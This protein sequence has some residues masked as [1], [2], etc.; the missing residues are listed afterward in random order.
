MR[1]SSASIRSLLGFSSARK[2]ATSYPTVTMARGSR[3][4]GKTPRTETPSAPP[5]PSQPSPSDISMPI[6]SST[7]PISQDCTNN[8]S[9][10]SAL[11]ASE[12]FEF[13]TLESSALAGPKIMKLGFS[14]SQDAQGLAISSFLDG[15]KP[16]A[17]ATDDRQFSAKSKKR[18]K[19]KAKKA[20]AQGQGPQV[21]AISP[22]IPPLDYCGPMPA[23]PTSRKDPPIASPKPNLGSPSVSPPLAFA[24]PT[25][26]EEKLRQENEKLKK[27]L[28]EANRLAKG[29]KESHLRLEEEVEAWK[30]KCEGFS[31]VVR[32]LRTEVEEMI[33]FRISK[34]FET[35]EEEKEKGGKEQEEKE[36]ERK[37]KEGEETERKERE[38]KEKG[39]KEKERRIKGG[40]EKEGKE[41]KGKVGDRKEGEGKAEDVE[42]KARQVK[43]QKSYFDQMLDYR[44]RKKAE[45]RRRK[46]WWNRFQRKL[47]SNLATQFPM[48]N[49]P[50]VCTT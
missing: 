50:L 18:S 2:Q 1:L 3:G 26:A 22:D 35:M 25:K 30:Q 8:G 20:N 21:P 33:N 34:F 43:S 47:V 5:Q 32:E 17:Q 49:Y 29:L 38:A 46:E 45:D 16:P 42:L 12:P 39:R 19:R 28:E 24:E 41:K 37:E 10:S 23:P 6:P 11:V 40:K 15:E 7:D 14:D 27:E 48:P 31:E 9:Q 36:K 4:K 44:Q 13:D